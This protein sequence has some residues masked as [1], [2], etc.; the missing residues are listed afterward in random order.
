MVWLEFLDEL[1]KKYGKLG[2]FENDRRSLRERLT[3]ARVSYGRV[4]FI[5]FH[6]WL[7]PNNK[8]LK[9]VETSVEATVGSVLTHVTTTI[10]NTHPNV[11][12]ISFVRRSSDMKPAFRENSGGSFKQQGEG[13]ERGGG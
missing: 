2:W 9:L 5:F 10:N 7:L 8:T 3:V 4:E 1:V 11:L 12:D 6:K 13:G